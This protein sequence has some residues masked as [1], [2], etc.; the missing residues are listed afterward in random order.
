MRFVLWVRWDGKEEV[1]TSYMGALDRSL[2][3]V[4]VLFHGQA[5]LSPGGGKILCASASARGV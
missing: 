2:E 1:E 5:L 3:R 4:S